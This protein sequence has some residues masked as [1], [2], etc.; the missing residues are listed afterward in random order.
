MNN[1]IALL[2]QFL[3]SLGPEV[4]G[5][6]ASPLTEEQL[7]RIRLFALGKLGPLE[8]LELL[9]GIVDNET[10][11]HALVKTLQSQA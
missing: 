9:P 10:A 6:S 5:H 1:E 3:E 8:R 11:L 7:E 2:A 4:S